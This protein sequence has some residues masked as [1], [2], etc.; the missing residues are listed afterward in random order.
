[1]SRLSKALTV[2][3]FLGALSFPHSGAATPIT[4][5]ITGASQSSFSLS[6]T[7]GDL[8][9]SGFSS[10]A[11]SGAALGDITSSTTKGPSSSAFTDSNQD[12]EG[13]VPVLEP[14]S[15][16]LLGL[17]L[18]GLGIAQ[19]RRADNGKTSGLTRSRF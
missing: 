2:I 18:V 10:V 11:D 19:R 15:L 14:G 17:G 5:V 7:D 9:S 6:G 8:V 12:I 1:M 16:V 4:I 3:A 13:L